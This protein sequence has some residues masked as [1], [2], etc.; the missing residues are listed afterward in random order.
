MKKLILL[1]LLI[2]S[3]LYAQDWQ[4][5]RMSIGV[6][7]GGVPA[8]TGDSC[9]GTLLFS[10]HFENNDDV[11]VGTPT[12]CT[13]SP[14]KTI[15]KTNATYSTTQKSDG[16]YSL[17]ANGENYQATA[18]VT[19]MGALLKTTG[20]HCV[21]FYGVRTAASRSF[22]FS[23]GTLSISATVLYDAG[24]NTIKIT[25]S[26]CYK[27]SASTFENG[28]WTRICYSWDASPANG[29]EKL[30]VKVGANAWE[31]ITTYNMNDLVDDLTSMYIISGS[32]QSGG[33]YYDNL[34]IYSDYKHTE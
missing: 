7:G 32:A 19:N 10:A 9:T 18:S 1:L 14:T 4:E 12:G 11:T 27:T 22:T 3:L 29:S 15:T 5:A 20:T 21:D 26:D 17:S 16:S 34:K 28:V 31:E 13:V 25:Y 2:P 8:A 33:G 23:N 6:I 30:A 24:G